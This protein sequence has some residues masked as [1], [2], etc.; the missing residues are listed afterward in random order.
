ME[1]LALSLYVLWN[2]LS[3]KEKES[4][5]L[6]LSS[7]LYISANSSIQVSQNTSCT[8]FSIHIFVII[9]FLMY[10]TDILYSFVSEYCSDVSSFLLDLHLATFGLCWVT[11]SK[12][13][14]FCYVILSLCLWVKENFLLTAYSQ[15]LN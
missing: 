13:F 14:L 5:L 12:K 8:Y 6:R 1:I 10:C 7:L 2:T 11:I 15:I 9:C 3:Q 4:L